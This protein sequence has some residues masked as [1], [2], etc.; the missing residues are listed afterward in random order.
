MLHFYILVFISSALLCD[1]I[2]GYSSRLGSKCR[3]L[4]NHVQNGVTYQTM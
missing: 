2:V 1:V 3:Q 4:Q